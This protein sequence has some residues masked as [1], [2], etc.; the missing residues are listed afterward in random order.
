M[1]GLAG[2]RMNDRMPLIACI[3]FAF[4]L[5]GYIW[6]DSQRVHVEPEMQYYKAECIDHKG[7]KVCKTDDQLFYFNFTGGDNLTQT[8]IDS[9]ARLL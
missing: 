6:A 3:V 8:E 5:A 2:L 7:H 1:K 4:A 9:L